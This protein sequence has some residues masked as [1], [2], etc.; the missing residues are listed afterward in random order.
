MKVLVTYRTRT[1][2]TKKIAEAIYSEITVDK[3][4]KPWS[5]VESLDGYNFSFVG[6][7]IERMGPVEKD[8]DWLT[9]FVNGNKIALFVTHGAPENAPYLPPWLE[10]CKKAAIDAGAELIGFFN[11]QGEL[12]KKTADSMAKSGRP[13]LEKFAQYRHM[14]VGQPDETRIEAARAFSREIMKKIS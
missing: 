2:N 14:T 5:E 6:Y 10:K 11:A 8:I 13:D 1:G 12:S 4:I 3:E 7:P 9:T